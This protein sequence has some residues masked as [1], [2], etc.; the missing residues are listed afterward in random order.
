MLLKINFFFFCFL[1][2]YKYLYLLYSKKSKNRGNKYLNY[3]IT[4]KVNVIMIESMSDSFLAFL[5]I[6]GFSFIKR[7]K[8][9]SSLL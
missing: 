2:L 4:V 1:S 9:N 5:S 3:P 6:G 8:G 7:A